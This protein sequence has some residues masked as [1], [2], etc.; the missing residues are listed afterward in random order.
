MIT[1]YTFGPQFGL[2]DASP[3]VTKAEMLLKMA[4]LPYRTDRNGF[5]KA[6]K[7]KCPYID[8][9]GERIADSTFIRWHIEQKYQFD[10]DRG[11][12]SEQRAIAWAFEK[13][14]EDN[15]Y[16]ALV[17]ARWTDEAN[18]QKGPK[19]FFRRV[20]A[21]VRPIVVKMIRRQLRKTL[22]AQGMGRHSQAEIVA[23]ATRGVDSIADYLGQKPFFM[24]A[25]PTG[26]DATMFAFVAGTLCPVFETPIRTAAERHDNL[27]RYVGRMTAR[28]YPDYPEIAGC[29][30][31]A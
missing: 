28:Y 10:F 7:G 15:I 29:K 31:A 18:F 12:S 14:A 16:W 19:T 3:F 8:D 21:L 6:P 5:R 1:L 24:G 25:Q 2:P 4:N 22:Y 17:D 13:L 23:L 27:R 20:P 9:D 30:A 26:V 11:L